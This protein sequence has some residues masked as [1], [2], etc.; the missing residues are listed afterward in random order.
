MNHKLKITKLL[1]KSV[2]CRFWLAE[3]LYRIP[4]LLYSTVQLKTQPFAKCNLLHLYFN[5]VLFAMNAWLNNVVFGKNQVYRKVWI[6]KLL[7]T[8]E[9]EGWGGSYRDF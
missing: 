8:Y 2:Y 4:C 9:V 3:E 6:T 1:R 7:K 5:Q